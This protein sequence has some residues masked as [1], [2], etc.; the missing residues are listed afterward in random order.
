MATNDDAW[1]QVRAGPQSASHLL[2]PCASCVE[3][4]K[5]LRG[6]ELWRGTASSVAAAVYCCVLDNTEEAGVQIGTAIPNSRRR[7]EVCDSGIV[8]QERAVLPP[9]RGAGCQLKMCREANA[10]HA[11]P[12]RRYHRAAPWISEA[13]SEIPGLGC[14]E[15]AGSQQLKRQGESSIFEAHGGAWNLLD[16]EIPFPVHD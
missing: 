6:R 13:C 14:Y 9:L 4:G 2:S 12:G 5:A 8:R 7:T 3:G 10:G 1:E 11:D 15:E 16:A